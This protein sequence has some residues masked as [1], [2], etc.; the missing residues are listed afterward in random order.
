MVRV[1]HLTPEF[2]VAGEL[3]EADF[4]ELAAA[5][6]KSI[7]GTHERAGR[8]RRPAVSVPAIADDGRAG[9]SNGKRHP[10]GAQLNARAHSSVLQIWHA[11]GHRVGCRSGDNSYGR[12]RHR[13]IGARGFCKR[14]GCRRVAR[15]NRLTRLKLKPPPHFAS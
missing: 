10:R 3:T 6:F 13:H 8:S 9:A 7:G 11:L 14:R 1:V 12:R 15:A 5:G 2:A 4:S